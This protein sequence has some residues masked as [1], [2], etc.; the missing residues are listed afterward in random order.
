MSPYTASSG[1]RPQHT[2]AGLGSAID[3]FSQWGFDAIEAHNMDLRNRAYTLLSKLQSELHGLVLVSP[4]PG[5]LAS[6]I[7]TV[8]LPENVTS[9]AVANAMAENYNTVVK[10][11]GRAVFSA[12]GG[13]TM[14]LQATR[15][16]F[17]L[18]NS[19][20]DVPTL[21]SNF[22]KVVRSLM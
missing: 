17:H 18:F 13:P 11:T 16:T 7:I 2:L 4:P 14:P 20:D 22:A 19:A 8:G 21:V 1:T 12:E 3:Y 15:F 5:P 6:P 10:V 9:A